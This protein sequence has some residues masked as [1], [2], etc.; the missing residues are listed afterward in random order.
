MMMLIIMGVFGPQFGRDFRTQHVR[1]EKEREKRNTVKL[2]IRDLC[3]NYP[4]SFPERSAHA[5]AQHAHAFAHSV[6]HTLLCAA[7]L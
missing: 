3:A 5:G 7:V 1:T 4:Q 6:L 2:A